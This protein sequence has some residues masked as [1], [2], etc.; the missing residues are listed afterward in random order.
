MTFNLEKL[1]SI[2]I[3]PS[4]WGLELRI[5][6]FGNNRV[7]IMQQLIDEIGIDLIFD[8]LCETRLKDL[9]RELDKRISEEE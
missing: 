9:K 8:S 2:E 5:E 7:L 6:D 1:T 4:T 3:N